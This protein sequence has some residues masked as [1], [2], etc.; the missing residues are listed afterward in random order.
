MASHLRA[1]RLNAEPPIFRGCSSSELVALLAG[2]AAFWLPVSIL[3]A[4]VLGAP[5]LGMGIGAVFTAVTTFFGTTG[6][7]RI[8]RSRPEGYYRVRLLLFLHDRG[9]RRSPFVRRNGVLD[10]GR[11]R[12]NL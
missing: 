5:A 1:D 10:L 9:L 11:R 6:L 8:K 2:A 7:R 12:L 3:L 4:V